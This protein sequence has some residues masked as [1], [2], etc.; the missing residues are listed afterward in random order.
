M[1][2]N[3]KLSNSVDTLVKDLK[4]VFYHSLKPTYHFWDIY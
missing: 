3:A 1:N 4:I 2:K